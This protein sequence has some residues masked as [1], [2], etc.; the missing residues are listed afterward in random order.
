M[1][2]ARRAGGGMAQPLRH[3]GD[4]EE[5]GTDAKAELRVLTA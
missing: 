1:R 3:D 4:G 5:P 2:F